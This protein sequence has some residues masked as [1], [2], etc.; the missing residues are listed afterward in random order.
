MGETETAEPSAA[1]EYS[2]EEQVDA[3]LPSEPEEKVVGTEPPS[4]GGDKAPSEPDQKEI[5]LAEKFNQ[6]TAREKELRDGEESI[7]RE[8]ETHTTAASKLE[9]ANK[10]IQDFKDNPLEGLKAMGIDFKDVAEMVLNED[11]PTP[12]QRVRKLE[13]QLRQRDIDAKEKTEADAQAKTEADK[14]YAD[15]EQARYIAEAEESIKKEIDGNEDKYEFI[16]SQGAYDLV[17]EVASKVYA[18][19]KKLITWEEAAVKV[20]E[21][22]WEEHGKLA[23]TKKFKDKYQE[24]PA[25]ISFDDERDIEANYYGRKHIEELYGR[26]LNNQMASES[27]KAPEKSDYRTDEESKEYLAE[28]LRKMMEA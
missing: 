19:T 10:I 3:V 7:K 21:Y 12:D 26:S 15:S 2:S 16:R 28:K 23:G 4:E 24:V 14:K 5:D 11:K 17:F 22:L 27:S 9:V 18:E 6:V 1:P 25:K 13:D 8:R 20:E